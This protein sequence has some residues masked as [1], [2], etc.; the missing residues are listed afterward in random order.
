[1]ALKQKT[2]DALRWIAADIVQNYAT[3]DQNIAWCGGPCCIAGHARVLRLG[4]PVERVARCEQMQID[5]DLDNYEES[6]RLFC[7]WPETME[8][9]A[10]WNQPGTLQGAMA[11]AWRIELFIR[12]GGLI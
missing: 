5:L 4:I 2:I 6:K 8:L 1:M 11:G 10:A 7:F 9:D 3:Y 12:S